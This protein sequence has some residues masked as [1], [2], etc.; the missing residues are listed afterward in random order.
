MLE[1][2]KKTCQ[3]MVQFLETIGFYLGVAAETTPN[4]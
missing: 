1:N 2:F 3:E 4:T